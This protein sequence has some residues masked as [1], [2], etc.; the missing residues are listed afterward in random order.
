MNKTRVTAGYAIDRLIFW[1]EFR[2]S[3]APRFPADETSLSAV[4]ISRKSG[5]AVLKAKSFTYTRTFRRRIPKGLDTSVR[6]RRGDLKRER[7]TEAV[8]S[9]ES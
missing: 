5:A 2:A 9:N 1:L 8:A 6:E 4:I 7:Q 3:S